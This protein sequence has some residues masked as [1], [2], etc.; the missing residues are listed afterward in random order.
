MENT[1]D[2]DVI[3]IGILNNGCQSFWPGSFTNTKLGNWDSNPLNDFTD[4]TF[5]EMMSLYDDEW[6]LLSSTKR[7]YFPRQWQCQVIFSF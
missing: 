6:K 2:V 1:S 4:D 7:Q 3:L 5:L